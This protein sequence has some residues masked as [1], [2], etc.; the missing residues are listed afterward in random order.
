MT[1]ANCSDPVWDL[2]GLKLGLHLGTRQHVCFQM[3]CLQVAS[4][5]WPLKAGCEAGSLD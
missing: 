2:A 5:G 1:F 3:A 4:S